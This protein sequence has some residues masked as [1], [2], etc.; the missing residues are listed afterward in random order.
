MYLNLREELMSDGFYIPYAEGEDIKDIE[1]LTNLMNDGIYNYLQPDMRTWG[2]SN[3][4][5]ATRHAQQYPHIKV[6]PHN[7]QSQIGLVMSLHA[8][9]ICKNM[10]FVEDD[11]FHNHAIILSGYRFD[12]GQWF[13]SDEPG[14]GIH[15]SP[16]LSDVVV[17]GSEQR[18]L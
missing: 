14:W 13:V 17:K 7:W 15:L 16:S 1:S 11:R 12:N 6:I 2:M 9:K 18:I 4:L 8:A 10:V 3:I 5:R